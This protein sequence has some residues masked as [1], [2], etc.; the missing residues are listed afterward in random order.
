MVIIVNNQG[1]GKNQSA[2]ATCTLGAELAGSGRQFIG[3]GH[4][5]PYAELHFI[6]AKEPAR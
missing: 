6:I 2:I 1:F 4:K 5:L 3:V